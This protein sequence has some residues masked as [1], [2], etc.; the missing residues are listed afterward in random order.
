MINER[1]L[2]AVIRTLGPIEGREWDFLV[3]SCQAGTHAG[4]DFECFIVRGDDMITFEPD[5]DT[6][7]LLVDAVLDR[8]ETMYAK[9]GA[10][11]FRHC[12]AI[13]RGTDE[14]AL[15]ICSYEQ[16]PEWAEKVRPGPGLKARMEDV[17]NHAD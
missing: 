2:S 9:H 8:R 1:L 6:L 17:F 15:V 13:T 14:K 7:F 4:A 16:E 3:A 5:E 11:R 10:P 12:L